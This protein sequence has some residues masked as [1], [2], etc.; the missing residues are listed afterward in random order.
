MARQGPKSKPDWN[1]YTRPRAFPHESLPLP[2]SIYLSF[3]CCLLGIQLEIDFYVV[4]IALHKPGRRWVNLRD[5]FC[6]HCHR[7]VDNHVLRRLDDFEVG[8]APVFFDSNL[9]ERRDLGAGSN[10]GR[11]LNP[12]AVET[13]V[14][15]IAIPSEFRCASPAACSPRRIRPLADTAT[16]AG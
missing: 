8:N 9:N 16:F 3:R 11:R 4:V 1:C 2:R 7:F 12:C 10:G 15:H 14:Q 6:E 13:I 5:A